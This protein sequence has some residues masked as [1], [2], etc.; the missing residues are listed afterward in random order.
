[1]NTVL[2]SKSNVYKIVTGKNNMIFPPRFLPEV[3]F[4]PDWFIL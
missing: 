4:Q 3:K 2:Y 1:M